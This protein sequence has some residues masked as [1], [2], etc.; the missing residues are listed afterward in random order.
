MINAV[1]EFRERRFHFVRAIQRFVRRALLSLTGKQLI[2][3]TERAVQIVVEAGRKS[4]HDFVVKYHD[5]QRSRNWRTPKHIHLIVELYVKE[6]HQPR[7][8]YELRDH[9]I[10]VYDKV[11]PISHY[12]PT[13]QV[14]RK[15]D[16]Q[17]F[18]SLDAVG[19]YSVE[20]LLVV[21]ELI[22]IQEKTNYPQG[23]LTRELYKDFGVEDR[24][25]VVQKAAFRGVR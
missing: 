22:F 12:P 11:Q 3:T 4:E 10:S 14:Y 19:E 9:L 1:V 7:L 18:L 17:R 20:F 8:T 23:S 21:S 15:G 25:R 2:W 13:L 5:P 16:E 24:F 6:A